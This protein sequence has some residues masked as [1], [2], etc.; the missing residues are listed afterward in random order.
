MRYLSEG[1]AVR[2]DPAKAFEGT[3]AFIVVADRYSPKGAA[4]TTPPGHGRVARYAQ[5]RDY[6]KVLKQR[7]HA[8]ADSLRVAYPGTDYRTF[9]DT[10]PLPERELGYFAG[11][12]W[13]GKNTMLIHPRVGSY[14][15]LGVVATNLELAPTARTD[16]VPDA[17]GTC[18]RCIEACPTGAITPY[19]VDASKCVSYLTIEHREAIPSFLHAG[20][21]DWVF[22]CDVCQDVCPH[23]SKRN[24]TP[25]EPVRND[26]RPR[27]PHLN[28][29]EVARWSIE[30]WRAHLR[31]T[32]IKRASLEMLKRNASIAL[33]NQ[34]SE[35]G[36][37]S[38]EG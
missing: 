27:V 38:E 31:G 3:R 18:T 11:L 35:P 28:L 37:A 36:K 29:E 9:V 2:L 10:A 7:L 20:I 26:Y 14:F 13:I 17:C 15:V 23:N 4:A 6:H 32:P 5:G 24:D 19:S 12:G 21:R 22:G 30:D 8:L 16:L 1:I 25:P 34:H 33:G